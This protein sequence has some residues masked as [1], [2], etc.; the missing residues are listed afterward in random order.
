MFTLMLFSSAPSYAEEK[1]EPE[2]KVYVI[3][4][5]GYKSSYILEDL[6]ATDFDG[7]KCLKGRQVDLSW[8]RNKVVYVPVDKVS[9]IV[10]YDSLD[11]YKKDVET[12]QKKRLESD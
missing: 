2:K 4:L 3:Y 10:E 7:I 12:Y 8:V 5:E 6:E 9:N 1:A 11:Q